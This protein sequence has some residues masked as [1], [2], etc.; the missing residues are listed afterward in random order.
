MEISLS[1]N[2]YLCPEVVSLLIQ[3]G[4]H[5]H[6][7]LGPRDLETEPPVGN[8]DRDPEQHSLWRLMQECG[9]GLKPQE[10]VSGHRR[11][12]YTKPCLTLT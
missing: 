4:E 8:R 6:H 10:I 7:A 5:S 2:E 3:S 1:R 12:H 9:W 11:H